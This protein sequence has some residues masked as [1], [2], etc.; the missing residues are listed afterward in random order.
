MDLSVQ[1]L[2]F[3]ISIATPF[4]GMCVVRKQ[5]NSSNFKCR[6]PMSHLIIYMILYNNITK[7]WL[8]KLF[9]KCRYLMRIVLQSFSPIKTKIYTYNHLFY[10]NMIILYNATSY[11]FRKSRNRANKTSCLPGNKYHIQPLRKRRD[12]FIPFVLNRWD[13]HTRRNQN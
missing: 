6:F 11:W 3:I 1:L 4:T 9:Y 7:S 13:K 2:L 5:N 12:C 10:F 8:C